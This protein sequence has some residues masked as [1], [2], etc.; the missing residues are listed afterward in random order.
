MTS[1]TY[2]ERER[3]RLV[4]LQ[5]VVQLADRGLEAAAAAG[6]VG[7]YAPYSALPDRLLGLLLEPRDLILLL[8]L[9]PPVPGAAAA[10]AEH[11]HDEQEHERAPRGTAPPPVWPQIE[12]GVRNADAGHVEEAAGERIVQVGLAN[13]RRLAQRRRGGVLLL[14]GRMTR[15]RMPSTFIEGG[16]SWASACRR[17]R[18]RR[19]TRPPGTRARAPPS[20]PPGSSA[21][22]AAFATLYRGGSAAIVGIAGPA[23]GAI[24]GI[25][26]PTAG[27][28]GAFIGCPI[29]P[30]MAAG[31]AGI[32]DG[33]LRERWMSCGLPV[34]PRGG[35]G[36]GTGAGGSSGWP[37]RATQHRQDRRARRIEVLRVLAHRHRALVVVAPEEHLAEQRE[38][39]AVRP[40]DLHDP[41]QLA[42]G[43]LPL[44]KGGVGARQ[45]HASFHVIGH[46]LK[47]HVAHLDRVFRAAEREVSLAQVD[48]RR[49]SRIAADEIDQ[50]LD[51]LSTRPAICVDHQPGNGN[52]SRAAGR[53]RGKATAGASPRRA[54]GLAVAPA[55]LSEILRARPRP[56]RARAWSVLG[57]A[58][59]LADA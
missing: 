37:A 46:V 53:P 54:E 50:L 17:H 27:T 43:F 38:A 9:V 15:G 16:G 1:T 13:R 14:L 24:V 23:T 4:D 56:R 30:I 28:I 33:A 40:I 55:V 51:L 58:L 6:S 26:G 22:V 35:S 18:H 57:A 31:L 52:T 47:A 10:D 3:D 12:L 41:E 2:V 19:G 59:P 7:S 45:H 36:V 44:V 29:G 5:R 25:E 11:Q 48:E 8:L 42:L 32:V 20:Q 21:T 34:S 39:D 49:R